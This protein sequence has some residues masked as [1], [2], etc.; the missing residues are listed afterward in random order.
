M[1]IE[2]RRKHERLNGYVY[3]CHLEVKVTEE[4]PSFIKCL[5]MF[6]TSYYDDRGRHDVAISFTLTDIFMFSLHY[7]ILYKL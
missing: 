5:I 1:Y 4:N 7:E 2:R 3:E 6:R